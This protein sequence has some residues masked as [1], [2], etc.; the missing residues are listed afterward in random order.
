MRARVSFFAGAM[1]TAGLFA[2]PAAAEEGK[3]SALSYTPWTKYCFG[4]HCFIGEDAH[5]SDGCGPVF[6]AVL[7]ENASEPKRVLRVSVPSSVNQADGIRV[8]IDRDAPTARPYAHCDRNICTADIEAGAD[9]LD[10]LERRQMLVITVTDASGAA[11][12][13]RL[14]L[15]NF[16]LAYNGPAQQPPLFKLVSPQEMAETEARQA[17][18]KAEREARCKTK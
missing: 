14:P 10:R 15:A 4:G 7:I 16:A 8:G 3:P 13:V 2:A 6:A 18:E 17:R 12:S 1:I 11:V 9:L 5:A